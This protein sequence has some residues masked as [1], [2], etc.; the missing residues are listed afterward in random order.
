VC[1]C[2]KELDREGKSDERRKG[3]KRGS[4][5]ES[6]K[7]RK[8]GGKEGKKKE[9]CVRMRKRGKEENGK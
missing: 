8:K 9:V 7:E 6:E 3:R 2:V 1:V 4:A 5:C